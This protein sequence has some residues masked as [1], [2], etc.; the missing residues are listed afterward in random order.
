MCAGTVDW[1]LLNNHLY[2]IW[3]VDM[4]SVLVFLNNRYV[5]LNIS[6]LTYDE[7]IYS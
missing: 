1:T 4:S 7:F 3:F 5:Y 6:S 2:V